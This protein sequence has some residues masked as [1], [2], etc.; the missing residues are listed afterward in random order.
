MSQPLTTDIGYKFGDGIGNGIQFPVF[1]FCLYKSSPLLKYCSNG[2][3]D[4]FP[5]FV[6]CLQNEK[7]F[8]ID[9]IMTSLHW[10]RKNIVEKTQL[11]TGMTNIDLEHMNQLVWSQV[12]HFRYRL[13][14]SF[15]LSSIKEYEFV[16]YS[17]G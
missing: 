9:H 13:C 8:N 16:H 12:F 1:T 6:K 2:L 3:F 5:S 11:W 10:E 15:D 7:N 4:M 14:Y 17:E